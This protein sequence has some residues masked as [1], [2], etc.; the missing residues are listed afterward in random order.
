MA[1]QLPLRGKGFNMD[2]RMAFA[3]DIM[4]RKTPH[5]FYDHR[6]ARF[7]QQQLDN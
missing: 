2:Y 1:T 3:I 5:V 6:T 4:K 7:S